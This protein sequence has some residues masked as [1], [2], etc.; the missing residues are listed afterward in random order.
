[1]DF[2]GPEVFGPSLNQIVDPPLILYVT[3][4]YIIVRP[5]LFV[6]GFLCYESEDNHIT[7]T[8]QQ[9]LTDGHRITPEKNAR[10][11]KLGPPTSVLPRLDEILATLTQT[12]RTLL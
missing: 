7:S 3:C 5:A 1:M 9:E 10:A 6:R 2:N 8:K 4:D 11:P 12:A